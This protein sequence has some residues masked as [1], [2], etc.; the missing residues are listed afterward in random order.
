M[1]EIVYMFA[2]QRRNRDNDEYKTIGY[3]EAGPG[4]GLAHL[5]ESACR[6]AQEMAVELRILKI[7]MNIP[8]FETSNLEK[9]CATIDQTGCFKFNDQ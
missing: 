2:L 5:R 6:L 1:D 9:I 4:F 3:Y 7:Q 8:S